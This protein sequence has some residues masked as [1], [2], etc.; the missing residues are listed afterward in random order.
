MEPKLSYND[1]LA[2][3]LTK[4]AFQ[5]SPNFKGT[6]NKHNVSYTTLR[7][8]F[9]GEQESRATTTANICQRLLLQ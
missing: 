7:R 3:A 2:N 4:L 9:K 6:T 8:R 1:S 5:K